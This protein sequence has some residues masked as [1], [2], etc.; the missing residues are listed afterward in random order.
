MKAYVPD[1]SVVAAALFHEEHAARAGEILSSGGDL[2]APDLIYAEL[3][4]V[5]WKRFVR[6]ETNE[7]EAEELLADIRLLPLKLTS[8]GDLSAPAI[9]LAM[10]T[11]RSVYDCLYLALA[12]ETKSRMATADQ[13]LVHALSDTPL[14]DHVAWIGTRR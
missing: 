13:R 1:A 10:R 11:G 6:H 3:A 4:D 9:A 14:A 2:Y 8:C 12:V 7:A 5:I